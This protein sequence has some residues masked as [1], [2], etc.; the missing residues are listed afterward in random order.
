MHACMHGRPAR[1]LISPP[2]HRTR[3]H[4]LTPVN[5]IIHPNSLW[6]NFPEALTLYAFKGLGKHKDH[7]K[8]RFLD[9]Y[10]YETRVVGGWDV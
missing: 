4:K 9:T 10:V 8:V 6:Y 3:K 7:F 5:P 2:T 1:D